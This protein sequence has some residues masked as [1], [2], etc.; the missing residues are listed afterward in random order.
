[1]YRKIRSSW[2]VASRKSSWDTCARD[3]RPKS[4]F[5]QLRLEESKDDLSDL[6]SE[7]CP[8]LGGDRIN[9]R[10]VI[11]PLMPTFAMSSDNE[12]G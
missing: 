8:T 3:A 4:T 2:F 9:R 11:E 5:P 6:K 7:R 10:H 1:L 12:I